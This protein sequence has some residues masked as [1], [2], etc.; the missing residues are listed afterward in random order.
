[1]NI[2]PPL[3]PRR[4]FK[5]EVYAALQIIKDKFHF[6]FIPADGSPEDVKARILHEF[7]YQSSQ[8]L[9]ED[10]YEL[11]RSVEPAASIIKAVST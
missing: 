6:H 9:N 2:P 10:T 8:D 7:A 4:I 5:E 3:P 11:V 1:M